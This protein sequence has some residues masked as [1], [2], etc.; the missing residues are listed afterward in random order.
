[1]TNLT[2]IYIS[3]GLFKGIKKLMNDRKYA[4]PQHILELVA[5]G[6]LHV[7]SRVLGTC[8]PAKNVLVRSELADALYKFADSTGRSKIR[9]LD[10]IAQGK[11]KPLP[12]TPHVAIKANGV[13]VAALNKLAATRNITVEQCIEELLKRGEA[14]DVHRANKCPGYA[15]LFITQDTYEKLQAKAAASNKTVAS[16]LY[17]LVTRAIPRRAVR[18]YNYIKPALR[19][20]ADKEHKTM[21]ELLRDILTGK[22]E[23]IREALT[24]CTHSGSVPCIVTTEMYDGL[25][26]YAKRCNLT[27]RRVVELIVTGKAP[28]L[29]ATPA[30]AGGPTA[31]APAEVKAE[32]VA[33]APGIQNCAPVARCI[34]ASELQA[35][36]DTAVKKA[37]QAAVKEL[38]AKLA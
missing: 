36:V 17:K 12:I 1:M 27:I 9:A 11:V 6:K 7:D 18:L 37:L 28:H 21:S 32:P 15:F 26:R 4:S 22:A 30:A 14:V 8:G 29:G 10:M 13:M 38:L 5:A 33:Q 24:S 23:P 25:V 34:S 2:R 16:A 31:A 20:R 35:L 19:C 3:N